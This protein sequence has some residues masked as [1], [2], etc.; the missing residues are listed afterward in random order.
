MDIFSPE[1]IRQ[2]T[3]FL[4]RKEQAIDIQL[5]YI[6]KKA[7][8]VLPCLVQQVK[9]HDYDMFVEKLKKAFK[10]YNILVFRNDDGVSVDVSIS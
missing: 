6:A 7:E 1:S 9:Y 10:G 2:E 5:R 3:T 8:F 4:I